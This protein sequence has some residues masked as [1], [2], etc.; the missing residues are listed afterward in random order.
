MPEALKRDPS[1]SP[2]SRPGTSPRAARAAEV[3]INDLLPVMNMY[4]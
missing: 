4:F 1:D 2:G 3:L